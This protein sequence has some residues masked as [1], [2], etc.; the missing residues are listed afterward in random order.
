MKPII[1]PHIRIRCPDHFEVGEG[2]IVDDFSYFSTKLVV[3]RW[4]HIA[5]GCTVAGGG[6]RT[7]RL[8]D[9]SSVS[10]GVRIW[11][12]SD[13]FANDLVTI[14]PPECPQVKQHLIVGDVVMGNFSAVGANSVIMPD[15]QVP[16]GTVIGALSFVPPRFEFK[17]WSVYAGTPVRLVGARNE[18][19][20]RAQID[21]VEEFLRSRRRQS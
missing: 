13:D 17:P 18:V 20:V 4:S 3:G 7:F 2:S 9:Y 1:S 6:D 15:N 5:S 21:Q 10:S 11:C 8:G 12:T 14:L 19:S 16:D